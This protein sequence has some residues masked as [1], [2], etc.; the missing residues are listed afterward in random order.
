[1]VRQCA[2]CLRFLGLT[3]P[4]TDTRI[5]HAICDKCMEKVRKDMEKKDK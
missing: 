4:Y 1:M 2:W 5:T 3:E